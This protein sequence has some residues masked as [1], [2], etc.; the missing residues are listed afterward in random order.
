[1]LYLTA[2]TNNNTS[3]LLL[4]LLLL[5]RFCTSISSPSSINATAIPSS[6]NIKLNK[7]SSVFRFGTLTSM[8]NY[9]NPSSSS[10]NSFSA[11]ANSRT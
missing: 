5:R 7:Y 3:R 10:S 8:E 11:F 2:S 1:M 4:L 9:T 6:A